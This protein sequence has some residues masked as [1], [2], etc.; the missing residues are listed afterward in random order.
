MTAAKKK[1]A[2]VDPDVEAAAAADIYIRACHQFKTAEAE[3]K[4]SKASLVA[5]LGDQLSRVLPDGRTISKSSAHFDAATINR[6]AYD[7]TT[8]TVAPPPA[9]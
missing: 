6:A 3:K 1:A 9:V 8:V 2:R 7:S 5:W 4:K